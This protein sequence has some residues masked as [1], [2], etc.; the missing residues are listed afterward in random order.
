VYKYYLLSSSEDAFETEI[1]AQQFFEKK[2][3]V[4]P[5]LWPFAPTGPTRSPARGTSARSTRRYFAFQFSYITDA[6][7]RA[8]VLD[9]ALNWLGSATVLEESVA[10]EQARLR[11]HRMSSFW[12][13]LS[14]PFN[15]VTRIQVG[16]PAGY[17]GPVELRVFNVQGQL[18]KTVFEG[19]K[20]AGFHTFEWD[21]TSNYGSPVSSGIYFARFQAAVRC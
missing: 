4:D 9:R 16:I 17:T 2:Q 1:E 19:T 3:G 8:T 5:R 18:V 15:P 12:T 14:Q 6:A 21:G 7:K 10:L 13:E 11:Q 20:P